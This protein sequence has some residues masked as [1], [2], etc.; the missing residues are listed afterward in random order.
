MMIKL[1]PVCQNVAGW[2]VTVEDD[3]REQDCD[4]D[5]E[6]DCDDHHH[7]HER[8]DYKCQ[9]D[10]SDDYHISFPIIKTVIMI[11]IIRVVITTIIQ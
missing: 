7:H 11:L 10:N 8:S 6:E 9:H 5:R 2:P 4:D 1:A 3:H